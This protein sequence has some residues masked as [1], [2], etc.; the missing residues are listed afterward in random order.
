RGRADV[1]V[2]GRVELETERI[3]AHAWA[4]LAAVTREGVRADHA[5]V[6]ARVRGTL[7]AP[8]VDASV[9]A[10]DVI[11]GSFAFRRITAAAVGPITN[12][13]VSG[14]AQGADGTS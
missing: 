9:E 14:T 1:K 13:G 2:E 11:A 5:R 6:E 3:E 10:Q 7:D 12:L 4:D 8:V